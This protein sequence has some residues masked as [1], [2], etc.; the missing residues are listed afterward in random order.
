MGRFLEHHRVFWFSGGE[1][2]KVYG[3]SADWMSRNLF[4]RVESCFPIEDARLRN[5]VKA[6]CLEAYLADNS[7]AWELQSDGSYHRVTP[8]REKA[9]AAQQVLLEQLAETED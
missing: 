4:R 7:Q 8:G 1:E 2:D 5:R 9:R 3:S 6:E